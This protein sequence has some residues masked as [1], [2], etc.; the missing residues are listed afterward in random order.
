MG[1]S[2]LGTTVGLAE[3]GGRR[4]AEAQGRRAEAMYERMKRL[5]AEL[6]LQIIVVACQINLEGTHGTCHFQAE[7]HVDFRRLQDSAAAEFEAN[8]P[9]YS[10]K[11]WG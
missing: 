7:H 6:E 2:F 8:G 10:L 1:R 5:A 3:G 4:G 9:V 11:Q